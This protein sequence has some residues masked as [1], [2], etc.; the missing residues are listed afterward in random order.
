MITSQDGTIRLFGG[1]KQIK[2]L[3][4]LIDTARCFK[5]MEEHN[6]IKNEIFNVTKDKVTVEEVANIC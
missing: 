4:P 3:V 2:T 1:G 5:F 6:D